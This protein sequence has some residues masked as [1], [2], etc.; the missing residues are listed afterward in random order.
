MDTPDAD[1]A[2]YRLIIDSVRDGVLVQDRNGVIVAWNSS[3]EQILQMDG[4]LMRARSVR[5]PRFPATREDGSRM[6][7]EESPLQITLSTGKPQHNVVMGIESPTGRR[8]WILTNTRPLIRPNESLPYAALAT[9]ID[10]TEQKRRDDHRSSLGTTQESTDPRELESHL[11]AAK[12]SAEAASRAKSDF[13]ARMSHE[14]RTPLNSIIGFANVLLQNTDSRLHDTELLYLDRIRV[15]G[16]HLLQLIGDILDLSKIEAGRMQLDV[17][18]VDVSAIVREAVAQFD[19]PNRSRTVELCV[20]TPP[21]PVLIMADARKV[22]Q[23]MLNLIANALK[24]TEAGTVTVTVHHAPGSTRPAEI[25]IRDTGI[26][27]PADRQSAIFEP[28]EQADSS[29]GRRFGGT[30]LGLPISKSLCELMG[31]T[32]TVE[33]TPGMGSTF[34]VTFFE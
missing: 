24:F 34:R 19:T 26:G 17:R 23:I 29:I 15:N 14:L 6:P 4:R 25:E 5:D 30:G 1:S 9:F 31:A 20:H 10:I 7:P 13:L 33:S 32:L 21:E 27:I 12:E 18:Q 2:F 22:M 3:A 8:I 28:F 16:T 11:R